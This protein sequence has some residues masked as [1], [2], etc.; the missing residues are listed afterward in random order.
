M[1]VYRFL[2]PSCLHN[3]ITH[4]PFFNWLIEQIEEF[5]PHVI[6]NLGDWYEGLAGSRHARD[7]RQ[8]WSL[9]DEH[10]S[11]L[12]QAQAIRAASPESLKVWLYGNHDDNLFGIHA[13]RLPDDIREVANWRN[14]DGLAKELAD[15]HVIEN[16]GHRKNW[17]LGQVTFA[18]GCALTEKAP[19]DAAYQYAA[20]Y[21]LYISGHTHRPQPVTQCKERKGYLPYWYANPGTGIDFDRCYY[22]ERMSMAEWGRGV[23]VGEVHADGLRAGRKLMAKPNWSAETRIHSFAHDS[24]KWKQGL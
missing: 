24:V 16:Y 18:H 6:I 2:A 20:P 11:V 14:N 21:G 5:K 19:Q 17:N 12:E 9:F 10:R 1:A 13:D 3:P 22:M 7:P 15:W 4:K 23:V 8:K